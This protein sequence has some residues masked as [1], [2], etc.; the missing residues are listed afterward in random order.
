MGNANQSIYL[1]RR[2]PKLDG[3]VLEVGSKDWGNTSSFRDLYQGEYVGID[4][5]SGV[6]VDKV[7]DLTNGT[8]DLPLDHFSLATCCSVL[9]HVPKPWVLAENLTKVVKKFLYISV[10]WCWR[11]HPYPEDYY[12]F[13]RR[14]IE[15]LFPGFAWAEHEYSTNVE[16]EFMEAPND[17]QAIHELESS[18]RRVEDDRLYMPYIDIHMIGKK[19]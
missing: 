3:P 13:S 8:G 11:Y 14:G 9:E 18:W 16:G 1:K 15:Q 7:L 10:P 19:R 4:I 12:R 17:S 2:I 6:G 5:E